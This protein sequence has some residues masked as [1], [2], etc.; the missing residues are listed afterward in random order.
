MNFHKFLR[1]EEPDFKRRFLGDIWNF[2]G[3]EFLLEYE[4][5]QH[6]VI[7]YNYG[8]ITIFVND[9]YSMA[10]TVETPTSDEVCILFRT[11]DMKLNPNLRPQGL[12][13]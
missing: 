11:Y 3:V 7:V 9:N 5:W 1:N 2:K 4:Q 8:D 12:T 6:L 10:A 13:L